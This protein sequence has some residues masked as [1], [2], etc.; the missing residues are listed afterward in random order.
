MASPHVDLEHDKWIKK[1]KLLLV[2]AWRHG[3]TDREAAEKIEVPFAEYERH[4]AQDERLQQL[5]DQYVDKLLR[6][7]ADSI[8]EKVIAG[9]KQAAEWLLEHRHPDYGAKA[10]Y[11]AI[12]TEDSLADKRKAMREKI[13]KFME[14]FEPDEDIFNVHG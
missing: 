1:Y 4:L 14:K 7:A 10:K 6:I 12:D 13:D 2:H 5:R 3:L 9:D 8:G 11:E